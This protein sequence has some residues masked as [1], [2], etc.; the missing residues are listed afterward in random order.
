VR[1]S[2]KIAV[3]VKV[4]AGGARRI[5]AAVSQCEDSAIQIAVMNELRDAAA[6]A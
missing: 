1:R 3:V 5:G 6:P 4:C 2:T